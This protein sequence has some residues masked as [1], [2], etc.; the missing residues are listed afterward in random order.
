MN[1]RLSTGYSAFVVTHQPTVPHEPGQRALDDPAAGQNRKTLRHIGTF[2][3]LDLYLRPIIAHPLSEVIAAVAAVGPNFGEPRE[4]FTDLLEN[5]LPPVALSA[6]RRRNKHCKYEPER[7]Y[8][9]VAL[10]S[11]DVLAGV[12]STSPPCP[13]DLTL[14]LSMIAALGCGSRPSLA[15]TQMRSV[16]FRAAQVWVM[17]SWV[18]GSWVMG[19]GVMMGHG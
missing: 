9:D 16:S 13:S 14:W 4:L 12:E 8:Q 7:V 1:P 17:G 10:A 3:N 18:M 19:D 5:L 6:I 11:L 15:R 2:Y